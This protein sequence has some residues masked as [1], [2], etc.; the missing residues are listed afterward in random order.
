MIKKL[1]LLIV[2]VVLFSTFSCSE[3]QKAIKSEDVKVKYE[4]AEKLYDDEK[5]KKAVQ[6]FEDIAPQYAGKPQGER[7]YYFLANSY[8]KTEDYYLSAY[9]FERF[10]KSYPKSEK[11]EEALFLNSKSQYHL[12]PKYS[13]D[14][15]ETKTA[16]DKLQLFINK[17]PESEY[18][19][20][21]NK[22]AL[23]L[24]TKLE[25]KDFEVAKQYN[26]IRDYKSAIRAFELFLSEHPGSVF[27]EDALYG[28]FVGLY[29]LAIFSV[30]NKQEGRLN[31]AKEAYNILLRYYADTK[32]SKDIESKISNINNE[33]EK[34]SKQT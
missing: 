4:L 14:Q 32:Y 11:V 34:F 10:A 26:K 27:R 25:K 20:E 2:F 29:N 12:S 33:L 21:A 24:R 8:Y 7:I 31:D 18:L 13:I 30:Y 16:I 28:K 1:N 3:Y 5:Y 9:Q 22:M 17:Y 15:T 6:L 19:D 23:E